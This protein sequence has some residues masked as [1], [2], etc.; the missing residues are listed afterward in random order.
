MYRTGDL[1][2]RRADGALE[3]LGRLDDQVKIRGF[4]V[5]LGEVEAA[6]TAEPG[7]RQAAARASADGQT[8][9][10]FLVPGDDPPD[11]RAV[12]ENLAR[13]LPAYLVPDRLTTLPGLPLNH[14]GKLDRAALPDLTAAEPEELRDGG[15]EVDSSSA[16]HHVAAIFRR[17]LGRDGIGPDDDFF[18]LGGN[19]LQA[20]R[21]IHLIKESLGVRLPMALL[22]T[23]STVAGLAEAVRDAHPAAE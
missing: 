22:F 9:L 4:R 20:A 16:E 23:T 14:N 12:R 1:V 13:R 17:I 15:P 10:G 21:L 6:L 18:D 3:F 8:L 2:R 7:V 5:E 19:S 11:L